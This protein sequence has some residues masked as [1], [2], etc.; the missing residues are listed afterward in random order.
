MR[1]TGIAGMILS[2]LLAACG[3]AASSTTEGVATLDETP[4]TTRSTTPQQ[5]EVALDEAILDFVQCLRDEGLEVQD[6]DLSVEG[7]LGLKKQFVEESGDA[8]PAYVEDA[9]DACDD[10][11]ADM[12]GRFEDEDTSELED[13]L[14]AFAECMRTEGVEGFPDPD[15]SVWQPGAGLGPGNGPFGTAISD[16][17]GDGNASTTAALTTCQTLYGGAGTGG[18]GTGE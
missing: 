18:S 11:R 15:L 5:A 9:F 6:P 14:L 13:R 3:G 8:L 12:G 1:H 16:V 7:P 2:L 10:M 4:T 17:Q